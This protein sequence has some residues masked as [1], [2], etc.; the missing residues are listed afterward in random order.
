MRRFKFI[1]YGFL[2]VLFA[3]SF[4]GIWN[5]PKDSASALKMLDALESWWDVR[6]AYPA[7]AAFALGLMFATVLLPEFWLQIKPHM[8]PPPRRADIAAGTAFMLLVE[9]SKIAHDLVR[10]GTLRPVQYES[11]LSEEEKIGSRLRVEL[12]NLLHDALV[13]DTVTAWGRTDGANPEMQIPFTE[14]NRFEIDFSPRTL[15]DSPLWIHAYNR[16]NDPRGRRIGYVGIRFCKSQLLQ[17]FPL[18]RLNFGRTTRVSFGKN[19]DEVEI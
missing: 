16:G 1:W 10:G 3:L 5:M 11:H 18:R 8:F 2:A 19:F 15:K 14:W 4:F 12:S 9:R 7:V 17:A 6:A 13:N